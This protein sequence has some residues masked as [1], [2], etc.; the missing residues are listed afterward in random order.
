MRSA[1]KWR[2]RLFQIS[3]IETRLLVEVGLVGPTETFG[4]ELVDRL[5]KHINSKLTVLD[6]SLNT[7]LLPIALTS[8]KSK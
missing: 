3:A 8:T 6:Y 5:I 1:E 2:R 7:S 4:I